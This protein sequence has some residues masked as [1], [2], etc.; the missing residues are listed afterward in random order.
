MKYN[1]TILLK[2]GREA[3]LRNGEASDG[4]A[5][6]EVFNLTHAETDYLLSYPDENSLDP[7]QEAKYLQEKADSADGI[8]IIAVLDGRPVGMAGIEP[9]GKK[10]KVKHRADFGISILKDY[11]GL[12]LGRALAAAC[13]Q[14]AREAGYAQLELNAVAENENALNLYRSL[15][16]VEYGRNPKGFNSRIS[17]YQELVYMLLEL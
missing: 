12:G 4:A 7:E 8:E 10:Y 2:D 3:L 16:F 17:G 13:I 1:Q 5:V 9:V 15:G 6:Y 14:C 11:W